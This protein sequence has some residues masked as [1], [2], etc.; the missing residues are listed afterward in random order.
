MMI[1]S[2]C[3]S[4]YDYFPLQVRHLRVENSAMVTF[5][6][7]QY[8]RRDFLKRAAWL[9][10]MGTILAYLP[11]LS[12]CT[13][14]TFDSQEDYMNAILKKVSSH[15]NKAAQDNTR[16]F[17]LTGILNQ[18]QDYSLRLFKG[19][20]TTKKTGPAPTDLEPTLKK[21]ID[22]A[23]DKEALVFDPTYGPIDL[24]EVVVTA[25]KSTKPPVPPSP[26][27][28]QHHK[29]NSTDT[30]QLADTTVAESPVPARKKEL[31]IQPLPT[32]PLPKTIKSQTSES[33]RNLSFAQ[34]RASAQPLPANKKYRVVLDAGHGG[35]DTGAHREGVKEKELNAIIAKMAEKKIEAIAPEIEVIQRRSEDTYMAPKDIAKWTRELAPDAFVSFHTNAT[36]AQ[37]SSAAGSQVI[38]RRPVS[39][40][41]AT[42]VSNKL[43]EIGRPVD[44]VR[45]QALAVLTHRDIPSVLLESGFINNDV[46]REGFLTDDEQQTRYANAVADAVVAFV[47]R[48][49]PIVHDPTLDKTRIP[50]NI[51]QEILNALV[52]GV[53]K[54]Y[55]NEDNA[56]VRKQV[57]LTQAILESGLMTDEGISNKALLRNNFWGV[58]DPEHGVASPTYEWENGQYV[59]KEKSEKF[60]VFKAI[61]DGARAHKQF[62]ERKR[63]EDAGVNTAPTV[64]QAFAALKS[65]GYATDPHYVAKLD[66]I[67]DCFIKPLIKQG[68]LDA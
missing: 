14:P 1:R 18:F 44:Q 15:L 47:L 65:A 10:G 50:D 52:A 54:A 27:K 21:F 7:D 40:E 68:K 20:P 11:W 17:S 38:T 46:E 45:G 57:A 43:E 19:L 55:Q 24:D 30:K 56:T 53:N 58:K 2:S 13:L 32:K 28:P 42:V 66:N 62:L 51:R 63:Y 35:K 49:K 26:Q 34:L 39:I 6:A 37:E 9:G 60:A 4:A 48:Q 16:V 8:S 25:K 5:A 41:L 31:P 12:G 59:F 23:Q 36:E 22:T 33:Y 29:G 67:H 61:S 64:E 3:I